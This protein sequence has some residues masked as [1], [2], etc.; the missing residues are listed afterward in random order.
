VVTKL[1]NLTGISF[2]MFDSRSDMFLMALIGTT[3]FGSAISL[4]SEITWDF[5]N[6]LYAGTRPMH[7]IKAE[8]VGVL[9]G[10]LSA[11]LGAYFFSNQLAAGNLDLEAPQ[12]HAFAAFTLVLMGGKIM[13]LVFV[14]GILIGVF[15]ELLTGM[16]TAFGLGMYLPLN[17]TLMLMTGGVA[18]DFWDKH[19]LTPTAKK[20]NWSERQKTMVTLDSYMIATG[21]LVGEA[22]IG[23]AMAIYMVL[24]L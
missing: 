9:F 24:F 10:T 8:S 2:L 21:L 13:V 16:G 11:A 17:Y 7:L 20:K 22:L 12:A 15:A 4:S 1:T 5:K 19:W 23:T 18:R 14:T 3:V 6:A